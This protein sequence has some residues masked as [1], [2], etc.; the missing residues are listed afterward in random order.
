MSREL[1]GTWVM[2]VSDR[3]RIEAVVK[4]A[5]TSQGERYGMKENRSVVQFRQLPEAVILVADFLRSF[6]RSGNDYSAAM[7]HAFAHFLGP[8]A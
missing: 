4:P 2:T 7:S 1:M 8:S 6:S 5:R 3:R